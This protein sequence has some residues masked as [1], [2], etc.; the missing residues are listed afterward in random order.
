VEDTTF[1]TFVVG[2]AIGCLVWYILRRWTRYRS[3]DESIL[4]A[5]GRPSRIIGRIVEI[6]IIVV[7]AV[8]LL[9]LSVL[10]LE[11]PETWL[12]HWMAQ[13]VPRE[14]PLHDLVTREPIGYLLL[15]FLFGLLLGEWLSYIFLP[16]QLRTDELRDS[17]TRW[18]YFLVGIIALG[19]LYPLL[20][21]VLRALRAGDVKTPI[22]SLS[23]GVKEPEKGANIQGT[24]AF[25]TS[26][27]IDKNRP[28]DE[29]P[30][31]EN[32]ADRDINYAKLFLEQ[33]KVFPNSQQPAET[34]EEAQ[35]LLNNVIT[36]V[37][38]SDL[39]FVK[40]MQKFGTCVTEHWEH[41][42]SVEL[43]SQR[44]RPILPIY[45]GWVQGRDNR[46]WLLKKAVTKASQGLATDIIL[47]K[48][49][50]SPDQI[51][52]A[53]D[54]DDNERNLVLKSSIDETPC[55]IRA[56]DADALLGTQ[57]DLPYAAFALAHLFYDA[58]DHQQAARVIAD[59]LDAQYRYLDQFAGCN[60][61]HSDRCV[62]AA[63][64]YPVGYRVWGDWKPLPI[65]YRI[66]ME[67]ELGV[68]LE[69]TDAT[70]STVE[71]YKSLEASYKELFAESSIRSAEKWMDH[72]SE[73]DQHEPLKSRLILAFLS[74]LALRIQY[75]AVMIDGGLIP[76]AEV[77]TEQERQDGKLLN[78]TKFDC[79]Y[80]PLVSQQEKED[81]E[82]SFY[83]QYGTILALSAKAKDASWE[84][85]R[86]EQKQLLTEAKL[87]L[88]KAVDILKPRA[89]HERNKRYTKPLRDQL[90][91][92]GQ[93]QDVLRTAQGR[94]DQVNQ[95]LR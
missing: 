52:Q 36:P 87:E 82:G 43:I 16:P 72:C 41:F 63:D 89:E 28:L 94:L 77:M 68:I 30:A 95:A 18:G 58:G 10:L 75:Q 13:L 8:F 57:L 6:L 76:A 47:A 69:G 31:F 73:Q 24:S 3:S 50:I 40:L 17:H 9:W 80:E 74:T 49:N 38:N 54:L 15:G 7:L 35:N 67:Y 42:H 1:A 26:Q 84:I 85:E 46:L 81:Y 61:M 71:V 21:P 29:L 34:R 5:I 86:T 90:F 12:A 23:F 66:R 44:V 93:S 37:H 56:D 19:L 53:K 64:K 32:I 4:A 88:E 45:T 39:P 22:G 20:L 25:A 11:I 14:G 48:S 62:T 59:W 83:A 2:A 79:F 33:D 92:L 65:W 70:R 27:L 55:P 51:D 78:N 91:Y 60:K